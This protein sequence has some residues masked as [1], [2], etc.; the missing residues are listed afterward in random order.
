[1]SMAQ[2]PILLLPFLSPEILHLDPKGSYRFHEIGMMSLDVMSDAC[3][4]NARIQPVDFRDTISGDTI[5][6]LVENC[7]ASPVFAVSWACG[8]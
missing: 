5:P 1:M 8:P 3:P 2:K 7:V 6:F 4:Q